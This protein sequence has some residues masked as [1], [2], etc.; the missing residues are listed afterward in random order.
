V[1]EGA[2]AG[3][4]DRATVTVPRAG[5]DGRRGEAAEAGAEGPG[6]EEPEAADA[7]AERR[8]GRF[9]LGI[10]LLP[11]LVG[12]LVVA[13][14]THGSYHPTGDHAL[15]ELQARDVGVHPVLFGLYSRDD[16]AHPG[17]A[18][19]YLSAPVYRLLGEAT[20][21]LDLVALLV[22]GGALA[23]M[24][25]IARRLAGTP[26][27]LITLLAEALLMRTLGTEFL[28]DP[29]NPYVT[30]LPY[31]LMVFLTWAMLCRQVWA[32]PVG[33]GVATYLAQT[34]VGFVVLAMPLL[35]LGAAGL[36]WGVWR[37]REAAAG[38]DDGDSGDHDGD[39]SGRAERRRRKLMHVLAGSAALFGLLWVPTLIDALGSGPSNVGNVVRFF[40]HSSDDA[41]TLV[42]AWGAVTGQFA[43]PPEWL[44]DSNG[45]S[46]TGEDIHMYSRP[47]PVLLILVA[48]AAVVVWRRRGEVGRGLVIALAAT[49]SLGIVGIA[50]TVGGAWYYR[51]RWLWIAPAVA[52]VLVVWALWILVTRRWPE[53][54]GRVLTG[55]SLAIL[56]VLAGLNSYTAVAT[57][58]VMDADSDVVAAVMPDILHEIEGGGEGVI[59]VND[60]FGVGAWYSRGIVL[61]LERLGH[62][63]RVGTN[64][65]Y[66]FDDR[67]VWDGEPV[68]VE[69]AVV[70]DEYIAQAEANPQ[71]RQIARWTSVTRQE[72]ARADREQAALDAEYEA[73]RIGDTEYFVS[74]PRIDLYDNDLATYY[75]VRVYVNE[76]GT[77]V[78]G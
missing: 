65:R 59:V 5:G 37:E 44:I 1:D 51:L 21:S 47:A 60:M 29:W 55:L 63:V 38:G 33:V 50:R 36:V 49:I 34:H 2:G 42:E 69:L 30:V 10:T 77:G 13:F 78:A 67:F 70:R 41:H 39:P 12:A 75:E 6:R 46:W 22:N 76:A 7:R 28:R 45:Q 16:W 56:V 68:A 71:M 18:F 52:F 54:G 14:R 66:V 72:L 17:P 48:L 64:Q 35:A 32:L 27:M 8:R 40:R 43:V 53:R 74:S 25:L 24:A 58:T 26:V 20:V 73:R 57:D 61:E 4:S 11:L 62:D 15:I 31:G 19:A 9:A 23:G 3:E